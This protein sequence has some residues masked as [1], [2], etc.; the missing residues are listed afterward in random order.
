M[1]FF[2]YKAL[3]SNGEVVRGLVEGV[4]IDSAYDNIA[5][6]GLH[7]LN[8]KKSGRVSDFFMKQS[9][10]RGVAGK[11][12]IEFANNLA[13]MLRA[14]LTLVT[15]IT[16]LAESSENRA[17]RDRLMDIRRN[18]ELGS[19][20]S[21]ALSRHS[22]IFPEIF[23]NLVA[24]GEETGRLD[25]SLSDVA[26]HLQRMEDL[27]SAIIRALMYP[28]FALVGTAGALLF[29]LIYVLPKMAALFASMNIELPPITRFLI[30]SSAF[31]STYWYI[32]IIG[33]LF[34]FFMVK[35]LSRVER[36]KYYVDKA[37]LNMPI[38]KLIT[39]NKLLAL[40]A[41]QLRILLAAGITID[42][43]FDIMIKVVNNV[44]FKRTL[45]G[46][47]ED[48]MLGSSISAALQNHHALFPTLVM[49][50]IS[51]GEAT[52]NINEQLDHLSQHYLEKLDDISQKMGKLIE[53]IIIV[54]IGGMFMIIIL[55]L[56]AP[57]YDLI[58][59]MG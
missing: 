33:P 50:M 38:M 20:F 3:D 12:V 34:I 7:I 2:A 46:I 24:V 35:M 43:S 44:V 14:G 23:I 25:K 48:I 40:F 32:F 41:E 37:K 52:G 21:N 39:H 51:I 1:P 6:L 19:G 29:W 4:H 15:S 22:D 30:A 9:R 57:I 54:A 10:G 55:G 5:A 58:A 27:K 31:C 53:P 47:K 42:K 8:I 17:L 49:R 28:V 13:V 45:A 16:D 11:D 56:L 36:T 18:I 59:N 26:V